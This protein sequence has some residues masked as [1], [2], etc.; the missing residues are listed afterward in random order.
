[1][2]RQEFDRVLRKFADALQVKMA[3][4]QA[5][6]YWEAYKHYHLDDFSMACN[7]L[8]RGTPGKLPSAS[9]FNDNIA[10]AKEMRLAKEKGQEKQ[11]VKNLLEQGPKCEDP[12]E[13]LW[14]K[15]CCAIALHEPKAAY[16]FVHECFQNEEFLLWTESWRTEGGEVAK[17]WLVKQLDRIKQAKDNNHE[18]DGNLIQTGNGAGDP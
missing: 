15:C 11:F 16:N 17:F 18:R 8:G 2:I 5:D 1:M 9:F 4:A 7:Q 3:N 6:L 10:A 13:S 12:N 14:A